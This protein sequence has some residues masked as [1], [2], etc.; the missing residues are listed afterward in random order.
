MRVVLDTNIL[1]S[2][3]ISRDGL[4]YQALSLWFDKQYELVTSTW[5]LEEF[6][7]V[8]RYDHIK[9]YLNP[10]EVGT[11][12]NDLRRNALVLDSLPRVNYSPDPDDNPIIAAALAGEAQYLVSGDKDDVQALGKVAG[13]RVLTLREFMEIQKR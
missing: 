1:I 13:V 6:K 5:Q 2:A 10:I 8:T 7:R 9:P 11:F 12:I 3:F 4:S